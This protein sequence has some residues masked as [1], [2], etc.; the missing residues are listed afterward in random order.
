MPQGVDSLKNC[1]YLYEKL[2]YVKVY[3][4]TAW[5]KKKGHTL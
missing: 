5:P 3:V 4:Y 1:Q 2:V